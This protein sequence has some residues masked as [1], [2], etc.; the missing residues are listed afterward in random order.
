MTNIEVKKNSCQ[1]ILKNKGPK[2]MGCFL[3]NKELSKIFVK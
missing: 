2:K 1:Q 3:Q